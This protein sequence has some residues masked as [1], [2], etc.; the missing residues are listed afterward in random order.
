MQQILHAINNAGITPIE[1]NTQAVVVEANESVR[2]SAINPSRLVVSVGA[3]AVAELILLH[4]DSESVAVSVTLECNATLHLTDLLVGSGQVSLE[5]THGEGATSHIVAISTNHNAATFNLQLDAANCFSQVDTLQLGGEINNNSLLLNMR[6][7]SAD[8]S[9]RSLSKCVAS[10]RSS[11]S[12]EGLVYVA[13]DAQRTAA[14][15][16]CRSIMLSDTAHIDARPQL[17]IYAD[18]V[19][20]S[21]GATMGHLDSEA[22]FYMRQRGFS[23]AQARRVQIEGFVTDIV[24]KCPTEE[25]KESLRAMITDKLEEM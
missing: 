25:V 21:H 15:Q 24:D 18:D 4:G 6:H 13:Q 7:Q 16:N 10:G 1:H 17:E 5:V 2:L 9:S 3:G 20:C 11:L 22:I 23:E 14:E 12:F 19:K 8:C